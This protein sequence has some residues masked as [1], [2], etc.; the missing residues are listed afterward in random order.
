MTG[1]SATTTLALRCPVRDV[2]WVADQLRAHGYVDRAYLGVRLEPV[3]A[4]V[5]QQPEPAYSQLLKWMLPPK[6]LS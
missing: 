5:R 4:T 6:V 3:A 2:L 1:R